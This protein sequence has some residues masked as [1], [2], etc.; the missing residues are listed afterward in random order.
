MA[1]ALNLGKKWSDSSEDKAV[2]WGKV[3]G[4]SWDNFENQFLQTNITWHIYMNTRQ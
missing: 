1:M 4:H 3:G 2:L